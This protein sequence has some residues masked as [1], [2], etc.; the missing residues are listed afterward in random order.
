V[1]DTEIYFGAPGRQIQIYHPRNG[2]GATRIR[3]TATFQTGTGGARVSRSISGKRQFSLNWQQ[4]WYESYAELE[5]YHHG[6][7]GPGPF[8]LHD[9]GQPNWLTVNQSAATSHLNNTDGFTLAATGSNLSSSATAY[10]RGPRSLLWHFPGTAPSG[11]LTV[12]PS[13]S[14]WPG[15]PVVQGLAMCLW[16]YAKLAAAGAATLTLRLSWLDEDGEVL[17]N[18]DATPLTLTTDW[19]QTSVTA[20][21]PAG[22]VYVLCQ[23]RATGVDAG[24]RLHLDEFQLERGDSPTSWAPGAGVFPVAVVSLVERWPWQASNYRE[25]VTFILQEAGP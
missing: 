5:A 9:P 18:T 4:L 12:D 7:N 11:S 6:H 13:T 19:Q 15:I 16:A 24:M 21:P 25:S 8:V 10:H 14:T 23:A 3:P 20:T 22:A 1:T 17:S 2:V